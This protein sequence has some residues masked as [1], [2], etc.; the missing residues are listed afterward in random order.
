MQL[1]IAGIRA[2]R[3]FP[4]Y[5]MP[6]ITETTVAVSVHKCTPEG[7]TL[8]AAVCAPMSMGVRACEDTAKLV[9]QAWTADGGRVTYG[10]HSFDGKSGLYQM[11]VY[12]EWVNAQEDTTQEST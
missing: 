3:G 8:V 4:G 6:H 11:P 9:E 7:I 2:R 10:G 12:G 5:L 1:H